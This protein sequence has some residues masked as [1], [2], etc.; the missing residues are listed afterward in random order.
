LPL[1]CAYLDLI[2]ALSS[3]PKITVLFVPLGTTL[4]S[5]YTAQIIEVLDDRHEFVKTFP[6]A[7]V[8]TQSQRNVRFTHVGRWA[9]IGQIVDR[10][11]E[12]AALLF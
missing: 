9:A 10:S 1:T 11:Q 4:E 2:Y 5:T 8:H 6:I 7:Y 12:F 3:N